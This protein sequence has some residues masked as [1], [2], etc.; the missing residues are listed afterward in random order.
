M[1][2]TLIVAPLSTQL[3]AVAPILNTL[4]PSGAGYDARRALARDAALSRST[5]T[6]AAGIPLAGDGM[7]YGEFDLA[8]LARLLEAAEPQ[9][10]D[11]FVD[12]GSGCGRAVLGAAL[13]RPHTWAE[14][15]GLE[16]LPELHAEAINSRVRLDELPE[17]AATPIAPVGYTCADLWGEEAEAPLAAADVAFSYSVTWE[18]EEGYLTTLSS[19]LAR[20]L[21]DG[22]RACTV[23]LKLRSDADASFDL[24]ATVMGCNPETGEGTVGYVWRVR[25]PP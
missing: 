15:V 14:C 11:T 1:L 8:F 9:K 7:V 21:S 16:C 25:K 4:Y 24:V 17:L 18:S 13:L 22:A 19:L 20:R 12:L 6:S 3:S 5:T 2:L 23:D 10:G